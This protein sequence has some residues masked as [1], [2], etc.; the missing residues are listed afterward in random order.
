VIAKRLQ[1]IKA[2]ERTNST[3]K[4][5][6]NLI[7]LSIPDAEYLQ[8]RRQLEFL[9]LP[10]HLSLHE[11]HQKQ[12]YVYF[13]NRGLA[14][15]VVAM[16][17]GKDVEA[18]VVGYEGAV[19]VA[20]AVGLDRSPLRVVMQI[21]GDGFRISAQGLCAALGTSPDLQMRLNR[22]GVL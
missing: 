18:G 2:G 20:V 7:L 16:R 11:P 15:I 4:P 3:G 1:V 12:R 13:L 9:D 17:D 21:Q 6:G 14:S 5:V 22:Y 8:I 10:N 19:G